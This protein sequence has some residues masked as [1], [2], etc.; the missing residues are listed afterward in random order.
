MNRRLISLV[1]TGLLGMYCGSAFAGSFTAGTGTLAGTVTD[2]STN[3]MWQQCSA[4]WTDADCATDDLAI[5]NTYTW[6]AAISY[7]EVLSLGG[8]TDWR[9]PNIKELNSLVDDSKDSPA[10][11]PPFANTQLSYYWSSTTSPGS[12]SAAWRVLF[13]SGGTDGSDK[14]SAHYVRCVRGQ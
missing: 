10:I 7:C 11:D 8:L 3:F 4:G 5:P 9:L 13:D 14:T 6:E 2:N 12:S 1:L